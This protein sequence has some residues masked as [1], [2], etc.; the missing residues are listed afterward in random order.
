MAFFL[1]ITNS[2]PLLLPAPNLLN[3]TMATTTLASLLVTTQVPR[4]PTE[5]LYLL[6]RMST[7]ELHPWTASKRR[8]Y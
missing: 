8:Q 3:S 2:W 5:I 1:L 6:P 7:L 4:L